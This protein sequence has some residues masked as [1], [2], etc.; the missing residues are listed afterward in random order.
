MNRDYK[1]LY[2]EDQSTES[3]CKELTGQGLRVVTINVED[4]EEVDKAL[5]NR[6]FQAFLMDYRLTS[7]QGK[8]D[9]PELAGR[10]RTQA[11]MGE[12]AIESPI[13]L[14]TEESQLR[15]L[16]LPQES[17]NLFDYLMPKK[18]FLDN[19]PWSA[20]IISSFIET[21]D[22]IKTNKEDLST[23]LGI[24]EGEKN[25]LID[26]RLET[27]YERL[28][29]DVFA[30]SHFLFN[31]F[32]RSTGS[33]IDDAVL[34]ARFG[35]DKEKSGEAWDSL[36][37]ILKDEGC[38][39]QGI[40]HKAYPKWWMQRVKAWWEKAVPEIKSFRYVSAEERVGMLNKKTGL[41][42]A[43]AEPIDDDMSH[44]YWNICIATGKPLDPADGYI[45]NRRFK[46]EWEEN[47]YI[48]LKGALDHPNFQEY[49]SKI[50]RKDILA[51]G[52]QVSSN[53]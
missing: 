41:K 24:K 26:Y 22:V 45:C 28:K 40:M 7:K 6:S 36:K 51:Y 11:K 31:Y 50:D 17:Q 33:L 35:I 18:A 47:E 19:A 2:L 43:V 14:I 21:Y 16:K 38:Q 53:K 15:L 25:V 8:R 27:E 48:S 42:L 4:D 10:L 30:S 39:Y 37:K 44:E 9:A 13:I 1:I 34:T 5:A 12:Q 3:I 20:E 32:V 46:R 23:I 29:E 52:Q 49:L